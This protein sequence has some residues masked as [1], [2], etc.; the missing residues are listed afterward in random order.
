MAVWKLDHPTNKRPPHRA[1]DT[2]QRLGED[3]SQVGQ[4]QWAVDRLPGRTVT[5]GQAIRSMLASSAA[6]C[7]RVI[8]AS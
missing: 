6:R 7:S 4:K 5:L 3:L 1:R 8:S 2:M